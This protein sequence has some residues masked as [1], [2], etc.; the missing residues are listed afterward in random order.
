Y[1]DFVFLLASQ[2][3]Y[4][5]SRERYDLRASTTVVKDIDSSRSRSGRRGFKAH[6]DG[7][8]GTR[9]ERSRETA[10]CS[11]IEVAG[12]GPGNVD[13]G[14]RQRSGAFVRQRDR[15][16]RTL[17]AYLL[18]AKVQACGAQLHDC[19]RA[20]Q[21]YCLRTARSIV[22]KAQGTRARAFVQG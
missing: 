14:Q 22:G 18:I 6:G 1:F 21:R 4:T 8:A 19:A 11:A 20:S 17:R 12:V 15:L 2:A 5:R 10:R 7:T 3:L 16:G 9:R 13:V